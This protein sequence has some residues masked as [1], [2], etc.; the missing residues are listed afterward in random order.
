MT[1]HIFASTFFLLLL[2]WNKS[3]LCT[4]FL[5]FHIFS[6]KHHGGTLEFFSFEV[7]AGELKKLSFSSKGHIELKT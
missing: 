4:E 2:L 5:Y 3:S 6:N 1:S 7:V